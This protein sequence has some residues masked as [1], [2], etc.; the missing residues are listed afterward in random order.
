MARELALLILLA[1]CEKSAT[2]PQGPPLGELEHDR[3]ETSG[4]PLAEKDFFR[5]EAGILPACPAN[6]S[7]EA[8]LVLRALGD[9][10]V[11]LEYPFKFVDDK[12]GDVAIEG[13]GTFAHQGEKTGTMTVK[14]RAAK[15]G[16]A[17]LSGKFKLSVCNEHNCQ[18]ES[19]QIAIAVSAS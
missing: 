5:V 3:V 1:A 4:P 11:N 12:S 2:T 13:T 16:K 17:K 14:Y 19:P 15:P 18:I 10:H 6:T 9:Y 7:C 8:R